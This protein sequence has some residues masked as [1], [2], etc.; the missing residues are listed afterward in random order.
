MGNVKPLFVKRTA[1]ELLERHPQKLGKNFEENK[2]FIKKIDPKATK[3]L[4]NKVAGFVVAL[5]KKKE[6]FEELGGV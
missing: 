4:R 2:K 3:S 1:Q 5:I 6:H